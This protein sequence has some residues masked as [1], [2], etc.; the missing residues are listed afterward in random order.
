MVSNLRVILFGLPGC[1]KGTQAAL[2]SKKFSIPVISTGD[3][4]RQE[5]KESTSIGQYAESF[6][7]K[8]ELVPDQVVID[9]IKSRLAKSDCE[10]GYI[11]DGFPRNEPQ[12]AALDEA[13]IK[14]DHVI[15]IT[16]P[17]EDVIARLSGRRVHLAS[18]RVYHMVYNPPK[19]DGKDDITGEDLIQRADDSE[20]VV[21]NRLA[22]SDAQMTALEHYYQNHSAKLSIINGNR[23][24]E[25]VTQDLTIILSGS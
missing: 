24:V 5:I 12:A 8:G 10:N 17:K 25:N 23:P 4:L 15:Y 3:I 11:L 16:V 18:G 7:K 6:V 19:V 2:L 9:I 14:V 13:G 21:R 20:D 22:L 1:G